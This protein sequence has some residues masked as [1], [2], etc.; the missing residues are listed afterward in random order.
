MMCPESTWRAKFWRYV[1]S[2]HGSRERI[3][4]WVDPINGGWH[5]SCGGR[6]SKSFVYSERCKDD[7]EM[8][9]KKLGW[10]VPAGEHLRRAIES[11]G[12]EPGEGGK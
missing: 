10:I 6:T 12:R 5:W 7:A 1:R 8:T 4:V 3:T 9:M 11:L 2:P